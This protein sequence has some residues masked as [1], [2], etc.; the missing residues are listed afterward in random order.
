M[1][2]SYVKGV[3]GQLSVYDSKVEITRRGVR[4]FL[5]NGLSGT[6]VIPLKNVQG[7]QV[8][9]GTMFTNGYI[10]F[11][12]AGRLESGNGIFNAA[13]DENTVF[14]KK[15][16]NKLVEAIARYIESVIV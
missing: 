2:V 3:N 4:G 9:Y 8:K 16:D 15:K 7:I 11:V 6:K 5:T 12:V 10:Q 13:R 1:F 14:F